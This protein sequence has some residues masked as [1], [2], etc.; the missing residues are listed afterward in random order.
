MK[1]GVIALAVAT[2]VVVIGGAATYYMVGL[3]AETKMKAMVSA[4]NRASN[5]NIRNPNGR[6]QFKIANYK[7]SIFSSTADLQVKAKLTVPMKGNGMSK[8]AVPMQLPEFT[9]AIP[10]TIYHG[11]YIF[12]KN[13]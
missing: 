2:G 7:R 5:I 13:S 3:N 4:M 1:K 12:N 8:N 9:Y 11:P 6:V 10:L